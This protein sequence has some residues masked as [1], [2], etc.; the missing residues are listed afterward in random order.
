MTTKQLFIFSLCF[1][2]TVDALAAP[3]NTTPKKNAD[4]LGLKKEA[5]ATYRPEKKREFSKEIKEQ[6]ESL[7]SANQYSKKAFRSEKFSTLKGNARKAAKYAKK[8]I[9]ESEVPFEENYGD[10]LNAKTSSQSALESK[11]VSVSQSVYVYNKLALQSKN[12]KESKGYVKQ[13]MEI[14]EE[15]LYEEKNK[16]VESG[17][18]GDYV[19][20]LF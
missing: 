16:L 12:W 18:L 11:I 2:F 14:S 5:F 9:P 15:L 19:K 7:Q 20:Q 17:E 8:S 1:F 6:I 13:A 10:H 4:P 3:S